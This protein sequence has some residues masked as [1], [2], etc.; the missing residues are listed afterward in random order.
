LRKRDGEGLHFASTQSKITCNYCGKQGHKEFEC[1]KKKRDQ[2]SKGNGNYNRGNGNYNRGNGNNSQRNANPGKRDLK[3]VQCYKCN[4]YGHYARD[5]PERKQKEK[6]LLALGRFPKEYCA[7][8]HI[9]DSSSSNSFSNQGSLEESSS[10]SFESNNEAKENEDMTDEDR[11]ESRRANFEG[12]AYHFPLRESHF[13]IE[14]DEISE[15]VLNFDDQEDGE[16]TG[17]I[18]HLTQDQY[19][20]D[21]I[22]PFTSLSRLVNWRKA[23]ETYLDKLYR[24]MKHSTMITNLCQTGMLA[25]L[26][27]QERLETYNEV[28]AYNGFVT[29]HQ[30][31]MMHFREDE[32]RFVEKAVQEVRLCMRVLSQPNNA[33]PQT[34]DLYLQFRIRGSQAGSESEETNESDSSESAHMA[35][36]GSDDNGDNGDPS[37]LRNWG[38]DSGA[39]SHF[40]PYMSDLIDRESCNV[41][42]TISDGSEV[43]GTFKGK[44]KISLST[45]KGRACNLTLT[46]VIFVEGLNRRL[47]SVMAFCK[48]KNYSINFNH[49]G[50][51]LDFGDGHI[52]T[53]YDAFR[54]PDLDNISQVQDDLQKE[55]ASPD[56]SVDPDI[57]E[58]EISQSKH[59]KLE[60]NEQ[61]VDESTKG[62]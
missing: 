58:N 33:E 29:H 31:N 59:D 44:V 26:P 42:I 14:S 35:Y 57:N 5:C 50:G 13:G 7:M 55:P 3:D 48:N 19:D 51:F 39:T 49:K 1:R 24:S 25:R 45:N 60:N 9:T 15:E 30:N 21:Y 54:S 27:I 62:G 23:Q 11:L 34:A 56:K 12:M 46:N 20:N 36:I 17:L 10:N 53:S 28:L 47:F 37:D 40:T 38:V 2:E 6:A 16:G 32:N 18:H 43:T 4:K 41:G 61:L 8:A 52:A 22:Y